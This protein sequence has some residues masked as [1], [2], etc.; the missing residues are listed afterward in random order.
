LQVIGNQGR[1]GV[2]AVLNL[3]DDRPILIPAAQLLEASASVPR[4][5]Q[6]IGK[7][8]GQEGKDIE[9]RGLSAAVRP[10]QHGERCHLLQFDVPQRPVVSDMQS[11]DARR[12]GMNGHRVA[13]RHFSTSAMRSSPEISLGSRVSRSWARVSLS[14]DIA[15]MLLRKHEAVLAK[16]ETSSGDGAV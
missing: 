12:L 4:L 14:L 1:L 15:A 11:L 6:A 5:A 8:L 3:D 13:S 9:H 2:F 16:S 7:A 10:Q